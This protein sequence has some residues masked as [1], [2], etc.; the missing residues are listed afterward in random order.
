MARP[1]TQIGRALRF[2]VMSLIKVK[3]SEYLAYYFAFAAVIMTAGAVLVWWGVEAGAQNVVLAGLVALA[4]SQL[5][6]VGLGV[7]ALYLA[8]R[9]IMDLCS[10]VRHDIRQMRRSQIP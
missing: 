6:W 10:G 2:A 9:L 5:A 1:N 8:A 4:L 3:H 7:V